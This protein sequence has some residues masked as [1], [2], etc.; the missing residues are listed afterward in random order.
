MPAPESAWQLRGAVAESLPAGSPSVD[1]PWCQCRQDT[2]ELHDWQLWKS[3]QWWLLTRPHALLASLHP[4][5]DLLELPEEM[6][7]PT[8]L[9][10]HGRANETTCDWQARCLRS[11]E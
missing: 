1:S 5:T 10:T 2:E 7:I 4:H 9:R 11:S 8:L 6:Y 3:S